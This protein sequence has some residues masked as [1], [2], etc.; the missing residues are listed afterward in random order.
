MF[1]YKTDFY[2][3]FL[4][5]YSKPQKLHPPYHRFPA[6]M[7][8]PVLSSHAEPQLCSPFRSSR[9]QISTRVKPLNANAFRY[10]APCSRKLLSSL[11]CSQEKPSVRLPQYGI[12]VGNHCHPMTASSFSFSK[13]FQP[14]P[15]GQEDW[16]A[17]THSQT[18]GKKCR[19]RCF[20]FPYAYSREWV[21]WACAQS[22]FSSGS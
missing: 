6:P 7:Q 17:A 12:K 14:Y 9:I 8:S 15:W 16:K 19:W 22:R 21:E 4:D 5:K 13:I 2:S 10:S 18:G 3:T 11:V 1:W 20:G